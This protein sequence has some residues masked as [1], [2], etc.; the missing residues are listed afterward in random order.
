MDLLYF[1]LLVSS[2]IF[3]HESGH[4]AFAKIFGVKVL[5]FSIGFGPKVVRIRGKETEYC[6]GL[7]P[8]GGFVKMLEESKT[9]EPILPEDRGR[10][11]ESQALWK[12]VVIVLAGPAM[13]V[14]FPVALYT[15][16]FLDETQF[17]PPTVGVVVPGKPAEGKLEPGDRITSVDGEPILSKEELDRAIEPRAGKAV[18]LG[19]ERDGKTID[20]FVTPAD[21]AKV[22]EL[23]IVE[24][25]GQLGFDSHFP[26]AV[27]GIARR[28]APAAAV[29]H[30]FDLV[31]A[32][33]GKR[34]ERFVDLIDVL[35]ANRGDQIV[36]SYLRPVDAPHALGGVAEVGLL[37][38]GAATLT[39]LPPTPGAA[40]PT[41]QNARAADV[42]ART[43][44]ESPDM[45]VAFVPEASS[46][47]LAGLRPGDRITMLDGAP[48]RLWLT[49]RDELVDGKDKRHEL[50]WTRE[51]VAMRGY[52]NLRKER[53]D[54]EFGQQYEKYVFHT[55]HW[56][57]PAPDRLVRNPHPLSY[58]LRRGVE[59]TRSV[60]K[61]ISIGL[62]RLVEGRVSLSS[63]SGPI[64]MYDI[65]GKAGARGAADFVWTMAV[66][67]VNVGLINLLPIPVLDG[68]HL[69]FFLL[70][71]LRRRP[72]PMRIREV[73]SLVGVVML[74]LIIL[75]AFKNDVERR[76]DV[77]VSQVHE[78]WT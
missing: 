23:D 59:E 53:W 67:S 16:V 22:R 57:P 4:F 39:P 42:L 11:F 10:T 37:E 78:L 74:G 63:V 61:F 18:K 2:L 55:D 71:A 34:I 68:G 64:T 32:V 52:F 66:I 60:V 58:A 19:V 12:R 44:I 75:V 24:H 25:R 35:S 51:G 13:N 27:I 20:V 54:D 70:E 48:A 33:N 49:M 3:I 69:L 38:P 56:V 50:Q 43:G 1:V 65:A 40:L 73:A 14:L 6:I 9:K 7:L 29:L 28:D 72:L 46:E 15:S 45:Y 31:T 36:I 8:F 26:A 21:E 76:W 62:L 5:T 17:L 30:T 47:W 41:D 77:I